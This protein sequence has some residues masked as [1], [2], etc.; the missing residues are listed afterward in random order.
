VKDIT[1]IFAPVS[2]RLRPASIYLYLCLLLHGSS[3]TDCVQLHHIVLL[4]YST[5]LCNAGYT[6]TPL[7]SMLMR[8]VF[9]GTLKSEGSLSTP[10]WQSTLC[11]WWDGNLVLF[12]LSQQVAANRLQAATA[13]VNLARVVKLL[14]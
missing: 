4:C 5:L 7:N 2:T 13:S 3:D 12:T 10:A 8:S 11:E 14:R 6:D 1:Y 9:M